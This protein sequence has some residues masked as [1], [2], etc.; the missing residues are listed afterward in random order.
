MRFST[1]LIASLLIAFAAA[2]TPTYAKVKTHAKSAHT[3]RAAPKKPALPLGPVRILLTFDDGPAR[4]QTI[5]VVHTLQ[6]HK[7]AQGRGIVGVFF[8]QTHAGRLG[9][10]GRGGAADETVAAYRA[11]NLIA[12]HTGSRAD[13]VPHT[14]RVYQSVEDANSDGRI[15]AADGRTGLDSDLLRARARIRNLTG[16]DTIYVRPVGGALNK[17]V[18]A[19]Y[20]RE[21][22]R[23][24]L[25][26]V[27]SNDNHAPRPSASGVENH[28]R[29]ET[30]ETLRA[31]PRGDLVILFHDINL[32][33]VTYLPE[34]IAAIENTIRGMGRTPQF[35]RSR[36]EAV[37]VLN[38]NTD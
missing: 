23:C 30:R 32:R 15:T 27:D 36:A 5:K 22:M 34:Y 29:S 11:G 26:N 28:L 19:A 21:G 9:R 3:T 31:H 7:D 37:S 12:V 25:W 33:T 35:V 18:R 13:H 6:D 1:A 8:I 14:R 4:A 16:Q 24:I 2:A 17:A 38:R 10:T 20:G